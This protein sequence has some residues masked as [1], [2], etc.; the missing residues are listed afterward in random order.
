MKIRTRYAPSPTGFFHIGGARTALFNY[1]FAKHNNGDFILRIEDTDLIRNVSGG[2][3]SQI[4]NLEWMG[5]KIDESVKNPGIYGPYQQTQ[6]LKRYKQL[7]YQLLKEG[8]AYRCFCTKQ[9]L[10]DARSKSLQNGQTPKYNRHCLYL[11]N[12]EIQEKLD[13]KVPFTIRLK[14]LDNHNISWN[15][16]IRGNISIPSSALTDPVILKS[17]D[18]PMYNFCV[19]VDDHDMQI[20]HVLRGEE[21]ISNTPYQICIK[22]ALGWQD[23]NITYGHL[24]V[25]VNDKGKKLSKRDSSLKQFIQDY[26]SMGFL[27]QTINNFLALL[28]WAPKQKTEIFSLNEM[29]KLFNITHVSKS[30]AFFDYKKMLWISNQ[31]FILMNDEDYLKFVTSFV[32]IDFGEFNDKRTDIILL[33]KKQISYAQQLNDLIKQNFFQNNLLTNEIKYKLHNDLKW[34]KTILCFQ[35]QLQQFND[36][37]LLDEAKSMINNIKNITKNFGPDL[38]MP[39]RLLITGLDHGPELYKIIAILGKKRILEKIKKFNYENFQQ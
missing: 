36:C 7:A 38:F 11:T 15:D 14:I 29:I 1:L 26:R 8:K 23:D 16:L 24:S 4:S 30:P 22:N 28:G 3:E 37:I 33:F 17:N 12:Q 5:L 18:I 34:N 19:V 21:H 35:Q 25:I 10:D 13:K 6:K 2:I 9:E 20:T 31:Y 27:P 32:D 39:I